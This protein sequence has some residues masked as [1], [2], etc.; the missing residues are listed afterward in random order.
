MLFLQIYIISGAQTNI[1]KWGINA[2]SNHHDLI[3]A[4]FYLSGDGTNMLYPFSANL[5][6]VCLKNQLKINPIIQSA[7]NWILIIVILNKMLIL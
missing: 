7:V 3:E 5:H 4:L 6:I 1:L 2:L